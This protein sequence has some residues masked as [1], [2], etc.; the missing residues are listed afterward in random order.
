VL[1]RELVARTRIARLLAGYRDRPPVDLAAITD[2]LVRISHLV[3]DLP[4]ILELDINPLLA[5]EHGVIALD[6]RIRVSD[7]AIA[8]VD[9]FAIRPYPEELEQWVNW[10]GKRVSCCVRFDRKTATSTSS[11][12]TG[13]TPRTSG[14]ARS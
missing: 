6:A 8:G 4:Q 1:A 11:S 5:D 2:V 7:R 9:R 10:Q 13:W 14:F 3:A 12:S